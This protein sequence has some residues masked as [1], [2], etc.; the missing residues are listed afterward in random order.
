[1]P[2]VNGTTYHDE[3]PAEV[4]RV[5]ENAR[6]GERRIRLCYG[7]V[8]TGRDWLEEYDVTGRVGRSTGTTK[9]PLILANSRSSGGPGILDHC[10]VRITTSTK[11]KVLYSHPL[12]HKPAE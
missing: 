6:I 2:V 10:I 9:I 8:K 11:G 5:L 3:T 4:I 1:M 7:D 12:Y